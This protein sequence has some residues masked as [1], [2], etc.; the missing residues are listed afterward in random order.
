MALTRS[1]AKFP[2][3]RFG[4][5]G[6]FN[7]RHASALHIQLDAISHLSSQIAKLD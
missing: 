2:E 7:G 3:L 1:G 6:G 5:E 4:L